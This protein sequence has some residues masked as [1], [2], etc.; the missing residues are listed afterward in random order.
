MAGYSLTRGLLDQL[1]SFKNLQKVPTISTLIVRKV[2]G[3][4]HSHQTDVAFLVFT[5]SATHH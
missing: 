2:T 4:V 3:H 1:K 5:L